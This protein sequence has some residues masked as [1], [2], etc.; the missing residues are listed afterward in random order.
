MALLKGAPFEK[1]L[2]SKTYED[3]TIQPIYR[4]EDIANLEQRKDFPGAAS[5]VRGSH[6]EGFLKAGWEVSQEL[7]AGSPVELNSMI[8]EGLNGGQSELNIAVG[9]GQAECCKGGVAIHT[10]DDVKTA[11]AGVAVDAVSTYWQTGAVKRAR[12]RA[13]HRRR[14]AA[15]SSRLTASR[16]I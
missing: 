15:R 2:V 1:L 10:V 9:C 7:K 8:H 3:I 16:W 4:R 11:L 14:R 5:L 12:R 6:A 13:R